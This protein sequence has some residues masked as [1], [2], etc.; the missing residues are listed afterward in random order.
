[1]FFSSYTGKPSASS[2][3]TFLLR[4]LTC[5][6]TEVVDPAKISH[7]LPLFLLP[8]V[9]FLRFTLTLKTWIFIGFEYDWS[10]SK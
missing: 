2:Q 8:W 3:I 5:V 4:V 6:P 10:S 9:D 7:L 1:M